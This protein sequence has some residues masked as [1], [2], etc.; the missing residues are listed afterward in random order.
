M[1]LECL[2]YGFLPGTTSP[3]WGTTILKFSVSRWWNPAECDL[4]LGNYS[5][6]QIGVDLSPGIGSCSA[7]SPCALEGMFRFRKL[8]RVF[9]DSSDSF[10]C[11]TVMADGGLDVS[12]TILLSVGEEAIRKSEHIEPTRQMIKGMKTGDN[13]PVRVFSPT[14][15][16]ISNI[17]R[18]L[19]EN[20]ADN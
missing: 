1:V 9:P 3:G 15:E 4:G 6:R 14:L 5:Y 7:C 13:T 12:H 10:N 2:F 16:Q 8:S 17:S 19:A 20:G 11:A 18:H